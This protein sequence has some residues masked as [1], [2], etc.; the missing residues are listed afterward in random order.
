MP[1][2]RR[3]C[4]KL[5]KKG[6]V[7][8]ANSLRR[9]C[10]ALWKTPT[11]DSRGNL[12]VCCF[13]TMN[14]FCLG[15]LKDSS[16]DALWFGEAANN[17]R[18]MHIMGKFDEMKGKNGWSCAKC[19]GIDA[20]NL[21]DSEIVDFLQQTKQE[22]LIKPYLKKVSRG[23][24]KIES[25]LIETTD[26]CNLD[27]IMCKQ[28][29]AREKF[30]EKQHPDR[31][32]DQKTGFMGYDLWKKIIDGLLDSSL[33]IK[34][35]FPA[36]LGE[37]FTHPD[38]W[39]LIAYAFEK[40]F[41]EGYDQSL[42]KAVRAWDP[43]KVEFILKHTHP[44]NRLFDYMEIH[45]NGN[46]MKK[47]DIE[48]LMSGFSLTSLKYL[49]FSI[50]ATTQ[51]TYE[52]IRRGGNLSTVIENAKYALSRKKALMEDWKAKI[53]GWSYPI[54][55]LQFIVMKQ[56][57][58]QAE[59]FVKYW[60][61][62]LETLGL[63][64]QVN[65]D[66]TPAF[67]KDTIF[68][69]RLG[70]GFE[71]QK[72]HEELHKKT[73]TDLGLVKN[74]EPQKRIIHAGDFLVDDGFQRK[75]HKDV[76][77][78]RKPCAAL[79]KTPVIRWDGKLTV[80]CFDPELELEVGDLN[81]HPLDV[82][83]NS[84]EMNKRRLIHIRGEFYK[85]KKCWYCSNIQ[86]PVMEDEEIIEYLR[87]IGKEEEIDVYLERFE[88]QQP[89]EPKIL[90][91]NPLFHSIERIEND[92]ALFNKMISS[93]TGR[94]HFD[95]VDMNLENISIIE[96]IEVVR[97]KQISIVAFVG[98]SKEA[99]T[100]FYFA[101]LLKESCNGVRVV[102]IGDYFSR[103]VKGIIVKNFADFVITQN[104]ICS[105]QKMAD[106]LKY[107]VD[108]FIFIPDL[109]WK[110]R[111]KKIQYNRRA[112]KNEASVCK[113]VKATP[114]VSCQSS[115]RRPTT[116]E[117]KLRVCILT[118][119]RYSK[120]TTFFEIQHAAKT[121][122]AIDNNAAYDYI[123]LN[124]DTRNQHTLLEEVISGN[125]NVICSSIHRKTKSNV[126]DVLQKIK[127]KTP[128]IRIVLFVLEPSIKDNLTIIHPWIDYL[129]LEEDYSQF[130]ELL[131]SI[132]QKRYY[133]PK[134]QNIIGRYHQKR[135]KKGKP[136]TTTIKKK[137]YSY[138]LHEDIRILQK[139]EMHKP[140][141][142]KIIF[143][144]PRVYDYPVKLIRETNLQL[145][146]ISS[147]SDPERAILIDLNLEFLNLDEFYQYVIDVCKPQTACI[148]GSNDYNNN[149]FE[150]AKTLKTKDPQITTI[151][152]GSLFS[153]SPQ[154][155]L[156]KDYVDYLLRNP[157]ASTIT[158]LA[159]VGRKRDI[160]LFMIPGVTFMYSQDI[161]VNRINTKVHTNN[162]TRS[163][164]MI[165]KYDF[166]ALQEAQARIKCS[167]EII[168]ISPNNYSDERWD[169]YS[170]HSW[171]GDFRCWDGLSSVFGLNSGHVS[172]NFDCAIRSPRRIKVYAKLASHSHDES[173]L[174]ESS[175]DI[176]LLINGTCMGTKTI[177][178]YPNKHVPITSWVVNDPEILKNLE[179]MENDNKLTFKIS[180]DSKHKN[181]ITI[182]HKALTPEFRHLE[183]PIIIELKK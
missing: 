140:N 151:F 170:M 2:R 62:E 154:S 17:Y 88:K 16:F 180:D 123:D 156:S 30:L 100:S 152:Y 37:P 143:I 36:W 144:N 177:P 49:V 57:K 75:D 72:E 45:T 104:N 82:L 95:Y 31:I 107:G 111:N 32:K 74:T 3:N 27:C 164:S 115:I 181:G 43:K 11:I 14:D 90:L 105:F 166:Q 51:E 39:A 48:N 41:E 150:I 50:D 35:V 21:T 53:R 149:G 26:N 128:Y 168:T 40:N 42:N 113:S 112:D 145:E 19:Q 9:P 38:M 47:Q 174:P 71:E 120:S 153:K 24:N 127:L 29:E 155:T 8:E 6:S 70:S 69:R 65:F 81:Q 139:N 103:K 87:N 7:N 110:D 55:V 94:R 12:T 44:N 85:I 97:C 126:L 23:W 178:F 134:L 25:L 176:M 84:D 13:D 98:C 173:G 160:S 54:I 80:C 86:S 175:S 122:R 108:N 121:A 56:N 124:I 130:S 63:E 162:K 116:N 89:K 161:V 118:P 99:S 15:N 171:D 157:T 102:F 165:K 106:N 183:M 172:F 132:E 5:P 131:K 91:V 125:Y 66:Y 4:L 146:L 52:K 73:V 158:L 1:K 137:S 10:P 46:L 182:Y 117:N 136:S 83:W 96:L 135:I 67:I 147:M 77:K 68:L 119:R 101:K 169:K 59:D 33:E 79:W 28:K 167:F 133:L 159:G 22:K 64:F 148:I 92:S 114:C 20:P 93:L 138:P 76:F 18:L 78:K 179:L 61:N 129:V 163:H 60:K 109:V 141:P 142:G 58:D 34:Q